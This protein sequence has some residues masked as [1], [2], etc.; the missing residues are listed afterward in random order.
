MNRK[1]SSR[2]IKSG[3]LFV[4]PQK[5]DNMLPL[6]VKCCARRINLYYTRIRSGPALVGDVTSKPIVSEYFFEKP[7]K[8]K[9]RYR[10][11]YLF[12]DRMYIRGRRKD[13]WSWPCRGLETS[14]S[15][16]S[17]CRVEHGEQ[18]EKSNWFDYFSFTYNVL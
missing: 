6:R 18:R 10:K 4:L 12:A 16:Y 13:Y 7:E 15:V 5:V 1:P 2:P 14:L 9:R 11:L 8:I 17:T 3:V